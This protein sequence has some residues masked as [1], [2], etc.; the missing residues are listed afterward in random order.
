MLD[1]VFLYD[2]KRREKRNVLLH[3]EETQLRK[4]TQVAL[5]LANQLCSTLVFLYCLL[6]FTSHMFLSSCSVNALDDPHATLCHTL[7]LSSL[8][9]M[10]LSLYLHKHETSLSTTREN[11]THVS[12]RHKHHKDTNN[13][14]TW[15]FQHKNHK[16][17]TNISLISLFFKAISSSVNGSVLAMRLSSNFCLLRVSFKAKSACLISQML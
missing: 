14:H 8:C 17:Q 6:V 4:E 3:S 11:N 15:Q 12:T 2:G 9:H 10:L 13:I 1:V 5:Q 16:T 7:F